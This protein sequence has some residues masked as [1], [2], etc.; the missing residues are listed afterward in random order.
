MQDPARFRL[1]LI[2][3]VEKE[4]PRVQSV[5]QPEVDNCHP[6]QLMDRITLWEVARIPVSVRQYRCA[7]THFFR[8]DRSVRGFTEG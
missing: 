4:V 3:N 1:P 2:Q 7:L 8:T 6:T 5:P